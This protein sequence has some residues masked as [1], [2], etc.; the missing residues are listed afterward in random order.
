MREQC[1]I[2]GAGHAGSQ[3]AA[4]L[5][6]EGYAG[7]IVLVS[8][9]HDLPYHKP[10]L[11]KA[12]LKSP[13]NPA[14][15]LRNA[16]FYR[17]NEI[18]IVHGATVDEIDRPAMAVRLGD[19]TNLSYTHLVLATGSR[20][21]VPALDG[22]TLEGVV[23]LRTL[24][25]AKRLNE[26]LQGA[27]DVV[28]VGGGF[29]GMEL[30][31][32]L[33]VLGRKVTVLEAAPRVLARSV[34]PEVSR[35]VH[36]RSLAAGIDIIAQGKVAAIG[37]DNGKLSHVRL[38]GGRVLPADLVILG[39]GAVPN[40]ELAVTAGLAAENGVVVD[41]HMRT[42]DPA[43]LAVGDCASFTHWQAGRQLRLESV[44][45]ATDQA[46]NAAKTI[47]GRPAPYR[48]VAWFWSDQG[49]MKLQTAGLAFD[50]DHR[51][52]TGSPE[53]NAFA[54]YHFRGAEL[55]AVDSVNRPAD[56]M[57]ARKLLAAGIS[58]SEADVLAGP[59]RLKELLSQTPAV[60]ENS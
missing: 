4:S 13:E 44:Q 6:Q 48:D 60:L 43:I 19:G 7:R 24:S 5:R 2:V 16:D 15:V 26:L 54:V 27:A 58:P 30:A 21:R 41:D 49:D 40:I 32:T 23:S 50:A 36:A 8:D 33:T 11:S 35:H 55:V 59:Q 18:E 57:I 20:P 10:P 22:A 38:E 45:N 46:K 28:I 42:S 3:A 53:A 37:D 14:L 34:A 52:I 56:H 29:I 47:A 25:D 51:I 9:E 17:D 12:F 31:H 39:V 1:V